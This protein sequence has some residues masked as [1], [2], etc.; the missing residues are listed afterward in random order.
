[1]ILKIKLKSIMFDRK[2]CL[3]LYTHFSPPSPPG[4]WMP[5]LPS[6]RTD[7]KMIRSSWITYSL[8]ASITYQFHKVRRFTIESHHYCQFKVVDRSQY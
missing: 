2:I 5:S 1:M 6:D 8:I 7:P 3:T 4:I